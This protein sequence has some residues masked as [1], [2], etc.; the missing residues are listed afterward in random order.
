AAFLQAVEIEVVRS[1]HSF[2]GTSLHRTIEKLLVAGGTGF[3]G[4]ISDLLAQR[5]NISSQVLDP[6]AWLDL[7]RAES[8]E[9][10]QAVAPIGLALSAL[11]SGGL[12]IDF[13]NPKKPA[14]QR[15]PQ[16]TRMLLAAVAGFALL[17]T[18][19]GVRMSLVK[20]RLKKKQEVQAQLTDAEK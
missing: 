9:T 16:R 19:F 13:A 14:V 11:E 10:T 7:K 2:E 3:E 18:L 8:V 15:N 12:P 17:L 4:A 1:V 6:A 5:L 20:K